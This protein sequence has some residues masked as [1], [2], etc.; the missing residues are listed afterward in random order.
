[1]DVPERAGAAE[2]GDADAGGA[3]PLRDVAGDVDA[4][5]MEGD[6]L[7]AR[8]AQ[9]REAVA[10]LLDAGPEAV[11]Q[12]VDVVAHLLR[13][14]EE[15][16]VRHEDGGREIV[17]HRDP[18]QGA[19][20]AGRQQPVVRETLERRRLRQ[21]PHLVRQLEVAAAPAQHLREQQLRP[22]GVESPHGA[23]HPPDLLDPDPDAV[24]LLHVLRQGLEQVLPLQPRIPPEFFGPLLEIGEVVHVP[25]DEVGD[26]FGGKTRD[27]DPFRLLP[28]RQALGQDPGRAPGPLIGVI[29]VEHRAGDDGRL[30]D[31][32]PHVGRRQAQALEQRIAEHLEEVGDQA[33][34]L[35]A[36]ERFQIEVE[37]LRD[38]Q[39]DLRAERA[40][41]VLDEVEIAGGDAE[42]LR[43]L[44]LA[45]AGVAANRPDAG[46]QPKPVGSPAEACSWP[47]PPPVAPNVMNLQIYATI[48][49]DHIR[50]NSLHF[51]FLL[52][53]RPVKRISHARR[54]RGVS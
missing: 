5:Q 31:L 34:V 45:Q 33:L 47:S 10:D 36:G 28:F 35:G 4:Q 49:A 38:A 13:R 15:A 42:T 46:A 6:P 27:L 12:E 32:V 40:L 25:L 21:Q 23:A 44:R 2:A 26:L 43:H 3:E 1:M 54:R 48:F 29:Q 52:I 37:L 19:R 8:A 51:R 16:V 20:R 11:P 9:R 50:F 7:G 22:R 14:L 24:G 18:A 30:T 39:E 41:V 17:G 53:F